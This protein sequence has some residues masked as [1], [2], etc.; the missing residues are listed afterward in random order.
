LHKLRVMKTLLKISFVFALILS[1][2]FSTELSAQKFGHVNI[3]L[4][5]EEMPEV[6]AADVQM[7]TFQN[8]QGAKHQA[9]IDALQK[10]YNDYLQLANSGTL[11]KLQM[12]QKEAEIQQDQQAIAQN[13]QNAQQL[14]VTKKQ[15]LLKPILQKVDEAIK[16]VGQEGSYTFI[17]DTSVP[18]TILYSVESEDIL[19]TLRSKLGF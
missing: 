7:T 18:N 19:A 10:K 6:K 2:A 17:F 1:T 9:M 5:L 12:S 4:L 13:E 11:S 8:E 3:N 15:E 14:I 16:Q